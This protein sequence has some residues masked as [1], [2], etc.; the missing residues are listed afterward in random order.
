MKLTQCAAFVA[1]V[2][3]GSFTQAA[4]RLGISQSAV[5]HAIAAL[6]R[7]LGVALMRR[8]RAGTDLTSDGR[9]AVHHARAVVHHAERMIKEM[10]G[11][12][13]CAGTLH[14][15]T[16]PSFAAR[17]LPRL[18]RGFEARFP[19]LKVIVKEGTYGQIT[20]WLR[21]GVVDVGV[22][23]NGVPE[24]T[25]VPLLRERM[26]ALLPQGHPLTAGDSVT[27]AQ[28]AQVPLLVP[29]GEMETM[30]QEVFREAGVDPDVCHRIQEVGTVLA[31]VEEG[32]GAAV[33]PELALPNRPARTR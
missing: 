26:C 2:E 17:L 3:T 28:L 22:V 24:L 6:E 21:Q 27:C 30:A 5:S 11:A 19:S 9:R 31:M 4:L 7:E 12:E 32:L 13:P 14:V 29:A 18:L 25:T 20:R 23:R 10:R 8:S 33:L 15:G 1:V 16:G